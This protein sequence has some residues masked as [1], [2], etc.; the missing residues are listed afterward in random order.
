MVGRFLGL[1]TGRGRGKEP[2]A[3]AG[4]GVEAS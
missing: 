1:G 4:E 2:V 3:Y